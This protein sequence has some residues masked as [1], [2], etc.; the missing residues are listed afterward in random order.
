MNQ[1]FRFYPEQASSYAGSYDALFAFLVGVSIFFSILIC[2]LVIGFAIKYRRRPHVTHIHPE[3]GNYLMLE[4]GWSIVPFVLSMIMFAWGAIVYLEM[5]TPPEHY[6]EIYVIGKQWMWKIQHPEGKREINELHLP[7][8]RPV[9]LK[10]ISEDVIHSFFVPEFRAKMD[11]LPGR[12]TTM[13]FE[14]TKVGTYKL[15]CTEYCGT[16]H[17]EMIGKVHVMEPSAY[18]AWLANDTGEPAQVAGERLFEQYKC[19]TCHKLNGEGKGPSLA[20]LSGKVRPLKNGSTVVADD[21]YIRESIYYPN[22]KVLTGYQPV[23]A[24]YPKDAPSEDEIRQIIAYI[25]SLPAG[26]QP[27]AEKPDTGKPEPDAN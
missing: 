8:G 1:E 4:I 17:S 27:A 5:K 12:Y 18:A 15:F 23:M 9:Q 24:A 13:W 26:Q 19:V 22:A 21:D 6:D 2:A 11:V 20:G 10:M 16:S 7:V 3:G 14:P 25:N